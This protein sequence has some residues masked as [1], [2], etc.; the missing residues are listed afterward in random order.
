MTK[1]ERSADRDNVME[2]TRPEVRRLFI[3]R[4]APA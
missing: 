4:C 2:L 1:G 3:A